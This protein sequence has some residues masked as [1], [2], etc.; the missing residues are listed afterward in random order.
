MP[1][2]KNAYLRKNIERLMIVERNFYLTKLIE[3]RENGRIKA[4]TGI[5]R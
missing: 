2:D 1:P 4:I 3:R 5:R